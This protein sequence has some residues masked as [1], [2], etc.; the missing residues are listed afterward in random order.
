MSVLASC[1]HSVSQP[2]WPLCLGVGMLP[3]QSAANPSPCDYG[4]AAVLVLTSHR[5]FGRSRLVSE[6]CGPVEVSFVEPR[7]WPCLAGGHR[8]AEFP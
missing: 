6:H 3:P 7:L 2:V 1:S 8:R 5:P 4:T